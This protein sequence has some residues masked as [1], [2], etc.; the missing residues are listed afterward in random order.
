MVE[1]IGII[2]IAIYVNSIIP[3]VL[4]TNRREVNRKKPIEFGEQSGSFHESSTNIRRF[5]IE[6][7][8]DWNASLDFIKLVIKFRI[9][10]HHYCV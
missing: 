3:F 2:E 6:L 5:A 1:W 7:N 9:Q 10:L 4:L 8:E